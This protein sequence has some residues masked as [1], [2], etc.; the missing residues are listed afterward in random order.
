[1]H[2][3]RKSETSVEKSDL[4]TTNLLTT[5]LHLYLLSSPTADG[6]FPSCHLEGSNCPFFLD[7]ARPE[8]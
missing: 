8:T 2:G 4:R 6:G 7:A 5:S 3:T 1:M